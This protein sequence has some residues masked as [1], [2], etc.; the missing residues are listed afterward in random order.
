M[1]GVLNPGGGWSLTHLDHSQ[2]HKIALR[3]SDV[4]GPE[5]YDAAFAAMR[6]SGVDAVLVPS[7]VRFFREHLLIIKAAAKHRL[8]TMYEWGDMARAGGLMGYGPVRADIHRRVANYVHKIL[9]GAQPAGLPVEQPTRFELVVNLNSA[10][11]LGLT[12]P[13]ALVVQMEPVR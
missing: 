6:R 13:H 5:G 7:L 3:L 2:A 11:A 8:P 9:T 10:D 12:L 1:I 4:P